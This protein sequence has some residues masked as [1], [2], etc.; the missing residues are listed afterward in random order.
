MA[1]RRTIGQILMN[2]GRITEED[3]QSAL[4]HQKENG[5]YFG[6]ALLA[7]GFV[8]QE[9]LEWGLA[10]QFDLPY[11]FPE[12]DSIDPEAAALVSPEWALANLTLPIMK[13]RETL[14][15]VVDSPIKT[16]QVDVLSAKTDLEIELALCSPDRIRELIREVYARQVAVDDEAAEAATPGT[17]GEVLSE[18]QEF[19]SSRFGVSTRGPRAWIWYQDEGKT[20]RRLL[21]GA[22]QTE[23]DEALSPA[24]S[25]KLEDVDQ[26]QWNAQLTVTGVTSQVECRYLSSSRGS[27]LMIQPIQEYSRVGDRFPQPPAGIRSEIKILARSGSARFLVRA[28]PHEVG[29]EILPHLPALLLD[30][31]LRALYVTDRDHVGLEEV[32][33]LKL[34]DDDEEMKEKLEAL[35]PFHF[36]VVTADISGSAA[37]WASDVLDIAASAFLLFEEEEDQRA[38]HEAGVKWEIEIERQEGDHLEWSLEPLNV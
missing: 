33:S 2:F 11:V 32:F 21:R 26:A 13:T 6:E 38:V 15:V 34:P 3:V 17:L 4:D 1:E 31:E 5:G 9:E 22:W 30:R 29:Q 24:P 23:L 28:T 10:S 35:R 12:A 16:E 27:E 18:I 14:T 25:E 7:L 36:D 37:P 8:S 20:L 19:R